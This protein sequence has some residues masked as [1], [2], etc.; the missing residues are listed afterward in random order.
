MRILAGMSLFLCL[1]AASAA[2]PAAGTLTA[3]N[4]EAHPLSFAAGPLAGVNLSGEPGFLALIQCDAS[5]LNDCDRYTLT[6]DLPPGYGA[7][8]PEQFIRLRFVTDVPDAIV[9]H[10]VVTD[11]GSLPGGPQILGQ[12]FGL[13]EVPG[14]EDLYLI[15][16]GGTR[17]VTVTNVP[18]VGSN[19]TV[20]VSM[21]L[22]TIPD[23]PGDRNL[24]H[25]AQG[26]GPRFAT[27]KPG[28]F[29]GLGLAAAEPTIAVNPF[30]GSVF[31][32]NT[33][34]TLRVRFDDR[35]RP[36]GA[37]WE[38]R[39]GNINNLATLDPILTGDPDTG[40]IFA[41]QLAGTQSLSE[42]SDDDGDTWFPGGYGFPSSGV[43]HQS[44]GVGPYPESTLL[45]ILHPLYPNAVYYCSQGVAAAFCSRSDDGGLTFNPFVPMY[46]VNDCVGLHGHVKVAP[47][48]TV[49][50]PNKGCGLGPSSILG[51]GAPAV[52]V[53]E[54]AGLTW[55]VRLISMNPSG[56]TTKSDPSVAVG[57]DNTVYV[58]YA[59]LDDR[60]RV[61]VS[62]DRGL[63]WENDLDVGAIAGV[64]KAE[65][66]AMVAGD[67]GRAA[68]AFL[69]TQF[70]VEAD[71]GALDFPG[72]WFFYIATTF[73]YGAHWYVEKV[74]P[75]DRAQGPG[76]IGPGGSNRNLL[77]FIDATIDT[78]GRVLAGYADGCV[79]ICGAGR[80]QNFTRIAVIARQ[81]GGRRMYAEFDPAEPAAP[82]APLLGGYRTSSHVVLD[83]QADHGGSP[84]TAYDVYRADGG[85]A[86]ALLAKDYPL[87]RYVDLTATNV[88]TEYRY[89]VVAANEIGDG[90]HSNV[91]APVVDER[92][93]VTQA[94]CSLPGMIYPDLVGEAEAR[95]AWR[96]IRHL[97]VAEPENQP[98]KLVL[99]L[100]AALPLPLQADGTFYIA[101]DHPNGY[102][103]TIQIDAT[104]TK[105]SY[106]DG[107][108][109]Q[110]LAGQPANKMA[111]VTRGAPALD[112]SGI[113]ASGAVSATL[114]K[115]A[116][117]LKTGDVLRNVHGTTRP[118]NGQGQPFIIEEAGYDVA[119][120][121]VG[122][123]FCQKGAVLP[124]PVLEL[125][126]ARPPPRR[127]RD[128]GRGLF[129]GVFAPFGLFL[130]VMFRRF[131]ANRAA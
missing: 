27:H 63:N 78:E 11:F 20:S 91:F 113:D 127:A 86:E 26:I 75:A 71:D 46:A 42:Y 37:V 35:T 33:L 129:L 7:A 12:S 24:A 4:D 16:N 40:R 53:S 2:E 19:A 92:A 115:E 31:F 39:H 89:R 105:L 25:A 66:P 97:A 67:A 14:Q 123:D 128:E 3:A 38:S 17:T 21:A 13:P 18:V 5:G 74:A 64:H 56:L 68:V 41:M 54:D 10:Y 22:V 6:I 8:H 48:G 9:Y 36:A 114:D 104:G 58:A 32:I 122:N 98:G 77:D 43:D 121:I 87:T 109:F 107:S 28:D 50:V 108:W 118:I 126:P 15:P 94:T 124:P 73:D 79:G 120:P 110:D 80:P 61:V 130:L 112:A 100:Q 69:G 72:T 30:T 70:P 62:R 29:A 51:E 96:D 88:A 52:L 125:P 57:R 119:Y 59:P 84:I 49:Y 103:Y 95:P 83:W 65:F 45:P 131:R 60:L 47:D 55:N 82:S 44:L 34:D 85:G 116:W 90:A 102:R 23:D 111:A 106:S 99:T 1:G 117:G 101:F 81:I 93:P 76:G